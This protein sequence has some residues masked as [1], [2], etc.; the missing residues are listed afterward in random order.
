MSLLALIRAEIERCGPIGLDRYMALALGH[1][2]FGYYPTRD[3]LGAAG[4]FT[5][6]PEISQMFGELLGLWCA[7]R[8][9]AL[10]RPDAVALVE[11]GPG[12]GTLAADA[13]RA[14]GQAMPAFARALRLHLVETSPALRRAQAARLAALSV[15]PVW[16]AT[17]ETLPDGPMLLLA[18]EF[19]DALPIR[20]W[21]RTNGGWCERRIGWRDGRLFWIEEPDAGPPPG[22]PPYPVQPG[23]IVE[24]TA[25]GH[26]IVGS[27]ARRLTRSG[28]AAL[29]VDYGPRR[30]GKGDSF[31][32]VRRHRFADPLD[33]PGTADLTAHVDFEALAGA[34]RAAGAAVAGPVD[35]GSFLRALGLVQ[36]GATL[37]R[38]RPERTG[39]IAAEIERLTAPDA[40]GSLFKAMALQAPDLP[41]PP[42]FPIAG[43]PPPPTEDRP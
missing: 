36:R 32:A 20:Q 26:A 8:W 38:A 19:F 5:T 42:G 13:L 2:A 1:P 21:R 3:P 7:E 24:H 28:G 17:V 15:T 16:H 14:I 9:A 29:I 18:N 6:A 34:A 10:G 11:L 22:W 35:Q 43:F 23:D 37:A 12:R 31:Q 41:P 25:I 39:A 27:L 40:M 4:D 30:S 33:A